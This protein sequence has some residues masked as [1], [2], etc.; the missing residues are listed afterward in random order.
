MKVYCTP[1]FSKQI[2]HL[3][4]NKSNTA[5][6]QDVCNY[7]I[8]KVTSELHITK[9]IIQSSS[10]VYSLNKFRI[11]NC[12]SN[13]GKSSSYRCICG[14][15]LQYDCIVLDTIYP[16]T[17]S[18]GIDNLAKDAYKEIATN[19]KVS[20]QKDNLLEID[21]VRQEIIKIA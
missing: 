8:D 6:L 7:F 4:K 16:K 18:D 9:D 20:F 10:K 17:G 1:R 3:K 19:I 15:F 12:L 2:D 13:K 14:V 5:V 21:L 11:S